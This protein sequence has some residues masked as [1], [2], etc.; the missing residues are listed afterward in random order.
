MVLAV[1]TAAL[2]ATFAAAYGHLF[3]ADT[4]IVGRVRVWL[5]SVSAS[6][7]AVPP[8]VASHAWPDDL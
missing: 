1:L 2:V 6:A 5:R 4:R 8:V 7:N 3:F